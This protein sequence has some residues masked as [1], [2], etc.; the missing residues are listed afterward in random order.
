[1]TMSEIKRLEDLRPGDLMFGPIGGL[2]GLGVGLG[3]LALREAFRIGRLSIR[4][5]G[6]V[7]EA[8]R[9]LPPGTVRNLST[10]E[11][12][13]GDVLM[14]QLP[15]AEPFVEWQSY[16]TG[17]I[18]TPRLVQAM[19]SG[20]EE[21][22]MKLDTHWTD[23]H[24]YARLPEDYPGQGEDAAAIARLMVAERV[25]YSFSS[26]GALALRRWGVHTPQLDA[27]I[28]RRRPGQDVAFGRGET[29]IVQLPCEAICSVLADQSWSLTGKR[30]VEGTAPQVVTPGMM[31][32]Q[33]WRRPGVVWGGV[34]ILG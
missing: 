11:W 7:V 3:Q 9:D 27:W 20:A 28:N 2:V 31:A 10:G 24:A 26:Y 23:R 32:S 21:I 15:R 6:I 13:P 1:M 16:P 34:G 19:P 17:V 12:H 29:G 14:G 25:A 30:V 33:L 8:S 4:H 5:V 18:T 22:D